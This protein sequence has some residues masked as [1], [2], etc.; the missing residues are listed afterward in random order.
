M[1]RLYE[2]VRTRLEE[3]AMITTRILRISEDCRAEVQFTSPFREE[4]PEFGAVAIVRTSRGYACYD[5]AQGVCF[6]YDDVS[7]NV[8][9]GQ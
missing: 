3:M 2:E 8:T 9:A 6:E 7:R 1:Y 4:D 5:Y